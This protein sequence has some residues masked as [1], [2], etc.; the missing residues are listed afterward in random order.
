MGWGRARGRERD[1][2]VR[3]RGRC[4]DS[5]PPAPRLQHLKV[6]FCPRR[7]RRSLEALIGAESASE[8]EPGRG[9]KREGKRTG[10][11]LAPSPD[12]GGFFPDP[13][14]QPAVPL[15]RKQPHS[16]DSRLHGLSL[17]SQ[18]PVH[19]TQC[20]QSPPLETK[21]G[22]VGGR[23]TGTQRGSQKC[24]ENLPLRTSPAP[25]VSPRLIWVLVHLPSRGNH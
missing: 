10:C 20:F 11:Y 4:P 19:P 22:E 23:G 21:S 12:L 5:P 24:E 15:L 1:A 7:K 3:G 17:P 25:P 8:S 9:E 18:S 13:P 14:T 6:L 2:A 16:P